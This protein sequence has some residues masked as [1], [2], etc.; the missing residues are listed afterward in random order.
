MR[1]NRATKHLKLDTALCVHRKDPGHRRISILTTH[2]NMATGHRH[3]TWTSIN[4]ARPKPTVSG[5][6]HE[7]NRDIK[8]HHSPILVVTFTR[9]VRDR[10]VETSVESRN[11][12]LRQVGK[13]DREM[14]TIERRQERETS[15]M[16]STKS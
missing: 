2:H 5:H 9:R 4:E 13:H 15:G 1:S 11:G 12:Q 14:R 16:E 8:T 3:E 10:I 7:V 6:V